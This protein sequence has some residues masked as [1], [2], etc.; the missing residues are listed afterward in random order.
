MSLSVGGGGGAVFLYVCQREGE[1]ESVKER[2]SV[3]VREMDTAERYLLLFSSDLLT[4][5]LIYM[6]KQLF[7]TFHCCV[8]D[9]WRK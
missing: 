4:C 1:R 8:R 7:I 2:E 3:C 6:K 9:G 5:N